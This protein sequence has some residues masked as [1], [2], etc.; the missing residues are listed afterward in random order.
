MDESLFAIEPKTDCPHV[1]PN[2]AYNPEKTLL[3]LEQ[4]HA[5]SL[6]AEHCPTCEE[7][8]REN[9]ENWLCLACHM[10]LCSRYRNEHML[11]HALETMDSETPHQICLSYSDLSFW[12]YACESYVTTP[13]LGEI[14]KVFEVAKFGE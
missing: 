12:C 6:I 2:L 4:S 10:V 5:K 9:P 7:W 3:L 14:R 11:Y 8:E 1:S 13:E